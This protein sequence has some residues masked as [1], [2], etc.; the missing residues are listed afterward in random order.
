MIET[1]IIG[2]VALALLKGRKATGVGS[3]K[4]LY[5]EKRRPR[6]KRTIFMELSDAQNAGIDFNEP[7][8]PQQSEI[9]NRLAERY[10]FN[11]A[12]TTRKDG[13]WYDNAE[14]YFDALRRTYKAISGIGA[15][16]LPYSTSVVRNANGDIII[17]YNDYGT[18]EQQ[19]HDAYNTIEEMPITD[20]DSA[21][22]HT[23]LYIAQ[24]GKIVWKTSKSKGGELIGRGAADILNNS[25]QERKARISYLGS[26]A[27]GGKTLDQL[28][29]YLWESSGGYERGT[30]DSAIYDGVEQAVLS[31]QSRKQAQ[32]DILDMYYSAHQIQEEDPNAVFDESMNDDKFAQINNDINDIIANYPSGNGSRAAMIYKNVLTKYGSLSDEWLERIGVKTYTD[33]EKWADNYDGNQQYNHDMPF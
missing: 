28:T 2:I 22:W 26:A 19:L 24:G 29:H 17:T 23:L 20:V 13:S 10:N 14:Q 16:D 18:Y 11:K 30:D 3:V 33:L 27:K 9:L 5:G 4:N 32:Q 1:L 8:N 12:L 15:T 6:R 7:Y 25:E 31:C 21:Y